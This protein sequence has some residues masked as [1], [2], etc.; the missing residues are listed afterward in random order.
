MN[1][2]RLRSRLRELDVP[3]EQEAQQRTWDVVERAFADREEPPRPRSAQ[4]FLLA[5]AAA[6]FLALALLSPAGA[7]IRHWVSDVVRQDRAR[8][9]LTSLPGP[10]RLLVDS[11]QGTWVVQSDG[12]QRLV[13]AYDQTTW[14][15]HGLYIAA[16]RGPRLSTLTP[17]GDPR[18]TVTETE[19]TSLPSW[20]GP[21][22]FRIAYLSGSS[23]RVVNGDGTGDRKLARGVAHIA[24][25]W[26]P[27][28][29]HVIAFVDR[30]GVTRV[31][32]TDTGRRLTTPPF[33]AV[34]DL[35]WSL[36][37]TQLA[38][39]FG[40]HIAVVRAS[41][42]PKAQATS[43]A[44]APNSTVE[45]V[46]FSPSGDRLAFIRRSTGVSPNSELIVGRP[47]TSGIRERIL[48]SAPGQLTDPTW[49]PDG[50]WLLVGWREADQWLFINTHSPSKVV[51]IA[52]IARQ[53]DPGGN[54]TGEFP[55]ISG[56]CCAP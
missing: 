35:A 26:R 51:A 45:Q 55:R 32:D 50:R 36:D 33:A 10:G 6:L 2:Q 43:T 18:W 8:P 40:S 38:V 39:G 19:P 13:G 17:N 28:T 29:Q 20:Q 27:G 47:H 54:G 9:G 11:E 56:W 21:D 15:P 1:E 25:V 16:T 31:V 3:G 49:S 7:A 14:S 30:V 37:G 48:F 42:T 24:P 52:N 22:G 5:A 41:G 44:G 12:S 53:F 46:A 34:N 4:R 23:L